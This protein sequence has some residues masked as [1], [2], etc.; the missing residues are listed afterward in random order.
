MNKKRVLQ[1]NCC[2]EFHS[3]MLIFPQGKWNTYILIVKVL[4]ILYVY[5]LLRTLQ[6]T[7]PYKKMSKQLMF[8]H[9]IS[10]LENVLIFIGQ[11]FK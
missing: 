8:Q 7:K 1:K 10:Q 4:K 11:K 3:L 2:F 9:F 6:L 5:L